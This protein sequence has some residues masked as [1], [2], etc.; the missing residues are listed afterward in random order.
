MRR[1]QLLLD[2]LDWRAKRKLAHR[3]SRYA[4]LSLCHDEMIHCLTLWDDMFRTGVEEVISSSELALILK[5]KWVRAC[6]LY[7]RRTGAGLRPSYEY[8]KLLRIG[9]GLAV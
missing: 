3:D 8:I 2:A 9:E 4:Q 5:G 7:R 1:G 6:Q